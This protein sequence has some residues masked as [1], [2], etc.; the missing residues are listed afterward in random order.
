M[1][2]I[3]VLDAVDRLATKTVDFAKKRPG[4]TLGGVGVGVGATNALNPAQ[5]VKADMMHE[6]MGS[7]HAKYSSCPLLE[8]FAERKTM[9]AAKISFEKMARSQQPQPRRNHGPQQRGNRGPIGASPVSIINMPAPKSEPNFGQHMSKGMGTALGGGV[10]SEGISGL[11]RVIGASAQAV[12]ERYVE[13]PKRRAIID[14]VVKKDPV[15]ST[16]E[17]EN[18]GQAVQ[19]YGTMRRFA[20]TLS[21]D[22]NVVTSFLRNSAMTGGPMDFQTIKGLADA[23]HAVQRARNEGAWMKGGL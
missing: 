21:T 8:K 5:K 10:V 19:A 3:N 4:L 20:P 17:R 12:S 15:V 16:A 1:K 9:L 2:G 23:E 7:P 22:P 18:P 6:Y 11:R 14:R 13:D